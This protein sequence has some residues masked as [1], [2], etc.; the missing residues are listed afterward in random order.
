MKYDYSP[1]KTQMIELKNTY[2]EIF[3]KLEGQHISGSVKERPAFFMIKG[4][5]N[6]GKLKRNGTIIEP[7]SGNTGIAL[8]TY[9]RRMGFNVILTMP[10]NVSVERRQIMKASGARVVLTP[11][12]LGMKGA[13][14][15]AFEIESE[16]EGGLVMNQ[17]SNP[18][19]P[20]SHEVTTGPEIYRDLGEEIGAFVAGV[21]TGG[22]ITGV[23]RLL[24]RL[25]PNVKIIAVEPTESAVISGNPKG[26][27]GIQG[28]G[29]GFIPD[30]FDR[31]IIDE[32]ITVST[33]EAVEALTYLGEKEGL[34]V[35]LSTGA[36]VAGAIKAKSH[37]ESDKKIV[38]ISCDFGNKYLSLGNAFNR[39]L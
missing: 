8:A 38:T 20:L 19:N 25:L 16:T 31:E 36:N 7:T 15:K 26:K 14:E 37:V 5:I 17:F 6:E 24:K 21:G 18:Y 33:D 4:A 3:L 13:M 12:E 22:T 29:A 23:G 1:L 10:E 9:G 27:H 32:V 34:F 28:I 35:G 2:P 11:G 39:K 30:N